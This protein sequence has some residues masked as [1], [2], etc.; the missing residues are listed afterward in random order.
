MSIDTYSTL[1]T[2]VT[3][4]M[5]RGDFTAAQ[6]QE[7]ITLAEAEMQRTLRATDMVTK[8]TAFTIAHEY[9]QVPVG[10][11]EARSFWITTSSRYP[12][13]FA[14]DE[15]QAIAYTSSGQPKFYSVIGN[16]FHFA[17][18]PDGTYTASL[19]YYAKF[20]AL[21]TTNTTN[22]LLSAWPDAYLYGA[23][24]H[25]AIRLQDAE[26]AAGFEALFK[27]AIADIRSA[28]NRARFG[29]GMSTRAV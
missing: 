2:A 16:Q 5:A 23:C 17:P 1:Q 9:E 14:S 28:S 11:L 22:W 4:R 21:S 13:Q 6:T 26:K 15:A 20:P 29:P 10:F 12:L 18:V 19:A 3:D 7:C 25:A 24:K 27:Q 8:T